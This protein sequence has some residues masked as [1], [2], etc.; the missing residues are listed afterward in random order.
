M[1]NNIGRENK[2]G[3]ITAT[4]KYKNREKY[5]NSYRKRQTKKETARKRKLIKYDHARR[6]GPIKSTSSLAV[7][8]KT[9]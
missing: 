8:R 1:Q 6:K 7:G 5:K 3:E 2:Q 9:K 4:E